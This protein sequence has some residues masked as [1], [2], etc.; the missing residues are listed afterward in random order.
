MLEK[1]ISFLDYCLPPLP[2]DNKLANRDWTHLMMRLDGLRANYA[3]SNDYYSPGKSMPI[4]CFCFAV[5]IRSHPSCPS[6][7]LGK[8]LSTSGLDS[9]L[10]TC[11]QSSLPSS[12][13]QDGDQKGFN[14]RKPSDPSESNPPPACGLFCWVLASRRLPGV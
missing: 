6:T 10:G 5:L 14:A 4:C 12:S 7:P 2:V 13:C 9:P 11:L 3:H 1:I 8:H